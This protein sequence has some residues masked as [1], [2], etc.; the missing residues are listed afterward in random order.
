MSHVIK[1][2][3]NAA[4]VFEVWLF[5]LTQSTQYGNMNYRD[6]YQTTNHNLVL[7]P[8]LKEIL[9]LVLSIKHF[10]LNILDGCFLIV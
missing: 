8:V 7:G 1:A 10:N 3:R 6:E 4:L 5:L 9:L 2:K